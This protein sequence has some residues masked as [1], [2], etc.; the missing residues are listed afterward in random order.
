MSSATLLP[1]CHVVTVSLD[2]GNFY[3]PTADTWSPAVVDYDAS[4]SSLSDA[5]VRAGA[6]YGL[7][8]IV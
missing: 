2:V 3:T 1:I 8:E 6:R 7:R 5:R 4:D